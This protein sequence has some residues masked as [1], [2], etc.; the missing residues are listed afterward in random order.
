MNIQVQESLFRSHEFVD[1][2]I[3]GYETKI[4]SESMQTNRLEINY[5]V[6][7]ALRIW[8]S[9][10]WLKFIM[11]VLVLGSSQ[12]SSLSSSLKNVACCKCGQKWLK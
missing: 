9:L 7:C 5:F 2:K 12:V 3:Q 6:E 4:K 10:S 1:L 11:I 8:V